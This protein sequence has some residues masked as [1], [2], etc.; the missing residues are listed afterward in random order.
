MCTLGSDNVK[1]EEIVGKVGVYSVPGE[2]YIY[3][4]VRVSTGSSNEY[5]IATIRFDKSSREHTQGFFTALP[6]EVVSNVDVTSKY[7]YVVVNI[8][9]VDTLC[10]YDRT[11]S[12][13]EPVAHIA[14]MGITGPYTISSYS[15][16]NVDIVVVTGVDGV[17][18]L[19]FMNNRL[20]KKFD[21]R[22][23]HNT[24][25][26]ILNYNGR[27]YL[28][29][30]KENEVTGKLD[31]YALDLNGIETNAWTA[32]VEML[33]P[34]NHEIV[35]YDLIAY[36]NVLVVVSRLSLY[37]Y[38]LS[39]SSL[40]KSLNLPEGDFATTRPIHEQVVNPYSYTVFFGSK[41]GYLYYVESHDINKLAS[42][43]VSD[44]RITFIDIIEFSDE[45]DYYLCIINRN[46]EMLV[47]NRLLVT[48]NDT[49]FKG[50]FVLNTMNIYGTESFPESR[51]A[52]IS[53]DKQVYLLYKDKEK[54]QPQIDPLL[55][56]GGVGNVGPTESTAAPVVGISPITLVLIVVVV[57]LV[58][59]G[60]YFF[61]R[62][63]MKKRAKEEVETEESEEKEFEELKELEI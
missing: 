54:A 12:A 56:I 1:I 28:L 22:I 20:N 45:K 58:I 27:K 41:N 35:G 37:Y 51:E 59:A 16:N 15:V 49:Q 33:F 30:Q 46:G 53:T 13:E 9:D 25:T 3:V 39:S 11:D 6:G 57:G 55:N 29:Y 47:Y 18:V 14:L 63:Q 17:W 4:P 62:I 19:V 32:N 43:R 38:D 34:L 48:A 23:V 26:Y 44:A 31:L 10:V 42:V 7:L 8:E 36:E 40:I 60:L 61:F 5:R 24:P 21:S 50:R 2:Y 52:I